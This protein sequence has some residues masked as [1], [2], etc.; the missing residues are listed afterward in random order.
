V[1]NCLDLRSPRWDGDSRVGEAET[2]ELNQTLPQVAC[3]RSRDGVASR[4]IVTSA[5]GFCLV[6]R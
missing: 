1:P 4:G 2:I 5:R 6:P 3:M